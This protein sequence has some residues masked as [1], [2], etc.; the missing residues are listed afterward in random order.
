MSEAR[1][2]LGAWFAVARVLLAAGFAANLPRSPAW[3]GG[4]ALAGSVWFDALADM[5]LRKTCA[6]R[7]RAREAAE[8]LADFG[9][10]AVL[11]ALWVA[12]LNPQDAVV[13][14]A[15]GFFV[16]AAATRLVR[17]HAE[18]LVGGRYRGL[19]TT[20]CGYAV[21]LM[22]AAIHFLALPRTAIWC[23]TLLGLS[24]AMNSRRLW[25]PEL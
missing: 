19:P 20:Y 24:W 14:A 9:G 1:K 18:G 17:F 7:T 23:A 22:A 12:A 10:F 6:T 25:V 21:P 11:P 4:V 15:C 2:D 5:W 3:V 16:A 8:L 13:L